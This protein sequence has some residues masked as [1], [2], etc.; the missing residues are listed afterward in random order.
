MIQEMNK[1]METLIRGWGLPDA[2][3]EQE[4][5]IEYQFNG[6]RIVNG[7]EQ[8]YFGDDGGVKFCLYNKINNKPLFSMDFHKIS[9]LM[10]KLRRT[11]EKSIT[12]QL[13][14]V[15]DDSLRNKGI[16]TFY[17]RKL[18]EYARDE[19]M[20][21]I[22]VAPYTDVDIFKNNMAKALS[23]SDLIKFYKNLSTPEMPIKIIY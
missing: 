7:H 19:G 15:I 10:M 21:Y 14:Y 4:G 13:L 22:N 23:R 3:K 16:A 12:L 5:D 9:P 6:Q 8:R 20:D 11:N 1:N 17:I 18:Q 2:L